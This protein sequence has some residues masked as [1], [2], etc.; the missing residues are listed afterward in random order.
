MDGRTL[1]II[2]LI[3]AIF[4]P[5]VGLILGIIALNKISQDSSG[6]K[7]FAI[8]AIIIDVLGLILVFLVLLGS[9]AYFGVLNPT[10]GGLL[11]ERCELQQGW[12]CQ[13][14][15][16]TS[17]SLNMNVQNTRGEAITITELAV[18]GAAVTGE[19]KATFDTNIENRASAEVS[20]TGCQITQSDSKQKFDIAFTWY[21]SSPT[22]T[23]EAKGQ[24]LAIVE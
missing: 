12:V 18:S 11:P 20:V 21:G 2:A 10:S 5:L 8:A 22:I 14:F 4:L 16:V 13:D 19:C 24:I 1:A 15:E 9:L 17:N 7:G 23:H 6:G 3:S